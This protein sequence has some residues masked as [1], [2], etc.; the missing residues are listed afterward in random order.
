MCLCAL[1]S[2]R[3]I[4]RT[5]FH[6]ITVFSSIRS[7]RYGVMLYPRLDMTSTSMPLWPMAGLVVDDSR[8]LHALASAF[9]WKSAT[10]FNINLFIIINGWLINTDAERHT[11]HRE[12]CCCDGEF[13]GVNAYFWY[14]T[15]CDDT[16]LCQQ[17]NGKHSQGMAF[18]TDAISMR[19]AYLHSVHTRFATSSEITSSFGKRWL[20]RSIFLQLETNSGATRVFPRDCFL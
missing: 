8:M 14:A 12:R 4:R 3:A 16:S 20:W 9:R 10:E 11:K 19:R 13:F 6:E 2:L 17:C 18:L 7:S 1:C 15:V 5:T